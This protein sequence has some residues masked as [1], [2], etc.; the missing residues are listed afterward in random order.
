[1]DTIAD[2]SVVPPPTLGRKEHE[3]NKYVYGLARTE[4]GVKL[5]IDPEKLIRQDDIETAMEEVRKEEQ[6]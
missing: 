4:D 2:D 6:S 5:L 3:H 1:M